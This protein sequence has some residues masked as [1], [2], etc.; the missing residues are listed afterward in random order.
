MAGGR[1]ASLPRPPRLPT[2]KKGFKSI[3]AGRKTEY[4][5]YPPLPAGF[6]GSEPE[7]L[8]YWA[9]TKLGKEPGVDFTFQS[10]QMGQRYEAG[11][12]TIDF[13]I[14]DRTPNLAIRIQGEYWHYYSGSERKA[15]DLVQRIEME[16]DGIEV[17]DIDEDDIKKDPIYYVS[18]ALEGIDLSIGSKERQL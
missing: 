13:M 15:R 1:R 10:A 16:T 8:C 5:Q 9:L 7:W 2:F 6:P 11:A 14:I 4:V 17:I 18:R 3:D 12:A